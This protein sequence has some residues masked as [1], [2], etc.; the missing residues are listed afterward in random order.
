MTMY[1]HL[2]LLTILATVVLGTALAQPAP[3]PADERFDQRVEFKTDSDG[4]SLSSMVAALARG[5][6]LTPVVEQVPNTP[7]I[8][9]IGDPKP[10]RQVWDIVL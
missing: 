3:L 7:V 9:D 2:V 5:I 1:K 6:G 4:E 8:Y 10:F